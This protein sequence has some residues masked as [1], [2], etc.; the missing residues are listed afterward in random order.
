MQ[1]TRN[2]KQ[3][4]KSFLFGAILTVLFLPFVSSAQTTGDEAAF[5][6][7]AVRQSTK[8]ALGNPAEKD[9][10]D[11]AASIINIVFGFLGLLAVSLTLYAGYIWMTSQGNPEKI[12]KA[13]DILKNA[14]IGLLIILSAYAIVLFIFRM[15]FGG[16]SL[17]GGGAGGGSRGVGIGSLGS[18]IIVSLYPAPNQTDVAR[19]TGII[20]TFREPINPG[21]ICATSTGAVCNGEIVAT[22]SVGTGF[23]PNIRIYFTQNAKN[24]E[25]SD[26]VFKDK[27]D[28]CG[29]MFDA[30]VYSTQDNR[31]FVFKPTEYLGSPSEYIWHTVYLTKN[32][33]KLTGQD[34]FRSYDGV[35][36]TSWSFEVSN[37]LD[38]EPPR[39][40]PAQLYPAPDNLPD[41][42]S[43]ESAFAQATGTVT[44]SDNLPVE[45]LASV[46]KVATTTG[47]DDKASASIGPNCSE[48]G[49]EVIISQAGQQLIYTAK[50]SSTKANLGQGKLSEDNK[51]VLFNVCGLKLTPGSNY[52]LLGNAAGH[53]WK[54]FINKYVEPARVTVGNRTY[55][56]STSFSVANSVF[57]RAAA[58]PQSAN[59]LKDL[60]NGDSYSSVVASVSGNIVTIAAKALGE[61]G[62]AI[63]LAS[64][65]NDSLAISANNLV[66]G[67]NAEK[68]FL[69]MSR[70]DK[71]RNSIVQINFS[72]TMNPIPLTGSSSFVKDY[73]R[74]IN[75][76]TT[77]AARASSSPCQDDNQCLSLAC[78]MADG[79]STGVCLGDYLPGVFKISNQYKTVEFT[80]NHQCGV[81]GCGQKIYCLP[82]NSF[83]K[84]QVLAASLDGCTAGSGECATKQPFTKC[85]S[86]LPDYFMSTSTSA[87][88]VCQDQVSSTTFPVNYPASK[89]GG[90]TAPF[91]GQMDVSFNSL[92]GNRD[93]SAQG[94]FDRNSKA[95]FSE[96]S[97]VGVCSGGKS[98]NRACTKEYETTICGLGAGC[99]NASTTAE[100]KLHGDNYNFSFWT[101]NEILTG[102]PA[103]STL[104]N[105]GIK[106]TGV[107]LSKPVVLNFNRVMSVSSLSTGRI[108][109]LNGATST[110]HRL[111]NMGSFSKAP[112]GYWGTAQPV[113]LAPQDGEMDLTQGLLNHTD[114]DPSADY[115]SEVG[116]GVNDINQNCYKPSKGPASGLDVG[117]CPVDQI[118]PTCCNGSVMGRENCDGQLKNN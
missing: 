19:N 33:K 77:L 14:A 60:I 55:T 115:W 102:A 21:T 80:S 110:E 112:V 46:I 39:V 29:K 63:L 62:N 2:R 105:I 51:S 48:D 28:L 107:N 59:S 84:V 69:V 95:Y 12:E 74:V 53:Y 50:S 78:S 25:V 83:I 35:R 54:V 6:G 90:N 13:K 11:I 15:F 45:R 1:N 111:M 109:A 34:A 67:K 94:P 61:G 81:N 9:P 20:V 72:E 79:A 89:L 49:V 64:N 76:T 99:Q 43:I 93:N 88:L 24:C 97:I 23:V 10:R 3:F 71:P 103:I 87:Y 5:G 73:I 36:D 86:K 118:T 65:F 85:D 37:K 56:A 116:S 32:I 114:F 58:G 92:D 101:N 108:M 82:G 22:T 75:A 4:F 16:G 100:A 38:L 18:G 96:N 70:R 66:G 27:K 113:D 41:I 40:E 42:E 8:A 26:S 98:A 17:P 106:S 7:A 47:D 44:V 91:D 52:G 30:K 104:D 117:I 31:T 57:A 68:K